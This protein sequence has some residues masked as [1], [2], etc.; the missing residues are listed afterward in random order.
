MK[1]IL[2]QKEVAVTMVIFAERSEEV[3]VLVLE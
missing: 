2:E 3:E 1:Q